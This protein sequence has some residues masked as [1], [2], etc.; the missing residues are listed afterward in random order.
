[1]VL[2]V[3]L[4]TTGPVNAPLI[5]DAI[6]FPVTVVAVTVVACTLPVKL[7]T[8]FVFIVAPAMVLLIVIPGLIL[9]NPVPSP[10]G[11]KDASALNVAITRLPN[12]NFNMLCGS[13]VV[14]ASSTVTGTIPLTP[15]DFV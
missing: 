7:P 14:T 9:G 11:T 15:C 13:P 2:P 12:C 4:P 5:V 6:T 8:T 10:E 1:M 3:R